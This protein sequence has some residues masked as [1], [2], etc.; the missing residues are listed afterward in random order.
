MSS[1]RASP[2]YTPASKSVIGPPFRCSGVVFLTRTAFS[3]KREP[4]SALKSD[5]FSPSMS[6][7]TTGIIAAC[8]RP[9]VTGVVIWYWNSSPAFSPAACATTALRKSKEASAS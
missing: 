8:C 1:M 2:A 6:C 5:T 3:G 4:L 7:A 9:S